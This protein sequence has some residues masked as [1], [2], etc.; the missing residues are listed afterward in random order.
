MDSSDLGLKV[1]RPPMKRCLEENSL[2]LKWSPRES[3]YKNETEIKS[4][5]ERIFIKIA[6]MLKHLVRVTGHL[7]SMKEELWH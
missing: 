2:P 1:Q 3:H 6:P 7:E 5:S 4:S